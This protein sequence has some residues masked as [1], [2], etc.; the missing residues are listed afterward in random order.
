MEGRGS[1]RTALL[2]AAS[3]LLTQGGPDA[4][5]LRDVGAMSGVSRTAPYRHFRDKDDLLSAVA[6]EN[7]VFIGNAMR[8][9]AADA[10]GGGSPLQRACVGYI[11][12]AAER[13]AH[14]R[15]VFGDF[16]INNPSPALEQAADDCVT[17]LYE[18][19]ANDQ[20]TGLPTSGDVRDLAA[21]IWATI[22]GLVDLTLAGHLR[23]PRMVNGTDAAPRLVGLM[24]QRLSST[25]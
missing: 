21:M 3:E 6:A 16:E 1:T 4:V 17:L 24:L 10:A 18:L 14:Y 8:E 13:P 15:L 9:A 23:E 22:H 2:T 20:G 11:R 5:T 19:V 25:A 7:L 12:A